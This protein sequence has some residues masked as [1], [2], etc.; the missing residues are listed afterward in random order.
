MDSI[1]FFDFLSPTPNLKINKQNRFNTTIGG[2][3]GLLSII[4]TI[5]AA[6]YFTTILFQRKITSRY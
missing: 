4:L 3:L 5:S 6:F 2:I 1:K